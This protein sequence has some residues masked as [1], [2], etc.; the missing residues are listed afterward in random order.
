M[1]RTGNIFLRVLSPGREKNKNKN[2]QTSQKNSR[3][4]FTSS[5][6]P[7]RSQHLVSILTTVLAGSAGLSEAG[8]VSEAHLPPALELPLSRRPGRSLITC[9]LL[10]TLSP[11]LLPGQPSRQGPS[12]AARAVC[13]SQW[14]HT[15]LSFYR[16]GGPEA[17]PE[18]RSFLTSQTAVSSGSR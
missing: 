13:N 5:S 9:G 7:Q 8:S 14:P 17:T 6:A 12:D 16:T 18:S 1:V 3:A 4:D 15:D 2:K 11:A 10:D